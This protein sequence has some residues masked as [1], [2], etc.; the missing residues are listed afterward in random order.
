[1]KEK[2]VVWRRRGYVMQIE[3]NRKYAGESMCVVWWEMKVYMFATTTMW[4][5][6]GEK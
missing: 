3:R 2:K 1:M 6:V 5:V 4:I